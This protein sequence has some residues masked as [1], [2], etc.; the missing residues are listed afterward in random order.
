MSTLCYTAASLLTDTYCSESDGFLA[1]YG[2]GLVAG[3]RETNESMIYL[4]MN[5]T[6]PEAN[7]LSMN[8]SE[9]FIEIETKNFSET[10][11]DYLFLYVDNKLMSK[12]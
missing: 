4:I 5:F 8:D 12:H 9:L 1:V 6:I 11:L 3:R 10:G 2:E 7:E